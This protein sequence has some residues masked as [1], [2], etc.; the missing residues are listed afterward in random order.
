MYLIA[1]VAHANTGLAAK[2]INRVVKTKVISYLSGFV[3]LDKIDD[4]FVSLPVK[5][6]AEHRGFVLFHALC[7]ER[8]V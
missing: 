5:W 8:S 2:V 4:K 1:N 3:S 7:G 6:R